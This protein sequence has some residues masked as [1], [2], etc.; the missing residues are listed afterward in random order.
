MSNTERRDFCPRC[1]IKHLAQ[2]RALLLET[3]KGYPHHVWYALGH[4]AEA[5]DELVTHMPEEVAEI[6]RARLEVEQHLLIEGNQE[7]MPDI[8]GLLYIVAK[9]ALLEE[10]QEDQDPEVTVDLGETSPN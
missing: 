10:V 8:N 4:I 2:A 5:E 7:F 6:R 3:K 9:G 1:A